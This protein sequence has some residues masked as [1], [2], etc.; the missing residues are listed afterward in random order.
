MLFRASLH[1]AI[2]R[3]LYTDK[4]KMRTLPRWIW[5][6]AGELYNIKGWWKQRIGEALWDKVISELS[7]TE[8][9][10]QTTTGLWF[11]AFTNGGH[12]HANCATEHHPSCNISKQ[13]TIFKKDSRTLG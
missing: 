2:D 8:E 9:K 7:Y 5:S 10:L 6:D 4:S 3:L 13:R 1:L 11:K 12:L